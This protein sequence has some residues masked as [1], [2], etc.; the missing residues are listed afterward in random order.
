MADQVSNGFFG[1]SGQNWGTKSWNF[2]KNANYAIKI[3]KKAKIA[4]HSRSLPFS[5]S[6]MLC[7]ITVVSDS[8]NEKKTFA[9]DVF[10]SVRFLSDFVQATISPNFKDYKCLKCSYRK[11]IISYEPSDLPNQSFQWIWWLSFQKIC[12]INDF[13]LFSDFHLRRSSKIIQVHKNHKT[14]QDRLN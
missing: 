2:E 11:N 5:R 7:T 9:P 8:G 13:W 10:L 4:R 14:T 1:V 3:T 12:E 6:A